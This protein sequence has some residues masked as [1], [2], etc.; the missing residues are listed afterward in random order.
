MA[1]SVSCGKNC[2]I[3]KTA[4]AADRPRS[5]KK[6]PDTESATTVTP[7]PTHARLRLAG[8]MLARV[9]SNSEEDP[10]QMSV[11]EMISTGEPARRP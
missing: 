2:T 6:Y 11:P 9:S 4:N 8:G 1:D 5:P 3:P 10:M 7:A